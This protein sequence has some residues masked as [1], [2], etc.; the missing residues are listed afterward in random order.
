MEKYSEEAEIMR[1]A[2]IDL[3][4]NPD[5]L[6]NLTSYLSMHFES[7]LKKFANTPGNM[8]AELRSFSHIE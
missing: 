3:A 1:Q 2:I 8:A 6:D 5:A 4:E 7:W